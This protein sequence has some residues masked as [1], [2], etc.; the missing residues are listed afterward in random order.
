MMEKITK[1]SWLRL[2]V[3]SVAIVAS[4]L[5]AFGIDAW[6]SD[7][8]QRLEEHLILT[9]LLEEFQENKTSLEERTNFNY[10]ILET[11]K[12]LLTL[13]GNS[14]RKLTR[15]E[16]DRHLH[17]INWFDPGSRF[18]TPVLQSLVSSGDLSIISNPSLRTSLAKW[19]PKFELIK[20]FLESDR[21]FFTRVLE[22]FL[23][24][25][26]NMTQFYS[27]AQGVPGQPESSRQFIDVPESIDITDHRPLL[28]NQVFE[29]I[30]LTRAESI[31]DIVTV[32]FHDVD[33]QL[34]ATIRL[35]EAELAK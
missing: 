20:G 26:T 35:I 32:G 23:I 19:A 10:A 17:D 7:R 30:L 15:E 6:W 12:L 1:T 13:S 21:E 22:P 4:I 9:E 34:D 33:L 11:T 29:N 14:D 16:M 5:L 8:Q 25:N 18:G 31:T 24:K 3:E 2:T 27:S 28:D